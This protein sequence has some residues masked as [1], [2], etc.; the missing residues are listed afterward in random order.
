MTN[1]KNNKL[2]EMKNSKP[3]VGWF[4]PLMRLLGLSGLTKAQRF[5]IV[6]EAIL[7]LMLCI[8]CFKL[9]SDQIFVGLI[10]LMIYAFCCHLIIVPRNWT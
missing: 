2:T 10:I 4:I 7:A 5:N 9:N 3:T 6:G 1:L 8:F